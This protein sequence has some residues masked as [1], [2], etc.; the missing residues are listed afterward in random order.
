MGEKL[1]IHGGAPVRTTPFTE[2]PVFDEGEEQALLDVLRSGKWWRFAFG[3]GVELDEPA[4]GERSQTVLFQEEFARYHGCAC[5]IAAANGTGTLEVGIR[6]LDL[7][8]GDEILCPAYTYVASATAILQNNLVPVFVDIDPDTYNLAP[9]RIEEAVTDR[10]RAIMVVHFGGQPADMDRITEIARARDLI[11]IEDAAH[12]HG[13]EWRGK[14]VGGL[15]RFSSFSFQASKNMTAGEGGILCTNDTEFA[16]ECD[17]LLWAGRKVGRPWYEFHRLGWNYRITEFQSAILRVQL[18]RLDEQIRH[19]ERMARYLSGRLERIDGVRPLVQDARCTLN[20][21]HIY[22]CRYDEA[23]VG[24]PRARFIEALEAEGVPAFGGYTFPLYRNPMFLNKRFINGA[25]P[26]GTAFHE[27]MD[28]AA[29]ADTCPVA[30]R[31]CRS[32]AIWLPQTVF[33]GT[34]RDMDD[35]AEAV[36]KVV[37][38]RDEL[39]DSPAI[40]R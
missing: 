7:A 14:K 22:M 36:G 9:D 23:G 11:V 24:V 8:V 12:A 39:L 16:A 5:G 34:Q 15:G 31:A 2:W 3:R 28:Y 20:G 33:L 13:C 35:I 27:D 37:K 6:A 32:E 25:F 19:R 18:A 10:T 4:A 40:G 17:S 30:E 21:C 26:L 29:F 1:A 38:H